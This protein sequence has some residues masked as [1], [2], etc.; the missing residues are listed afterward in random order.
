M[1]DRF[2]AAQGRKV[3]SRTTAEELGTV[4]HLVVD[5]EQRRIVSVVVGRRRKASLVDWQDLSGFGPDAIMVA[6][7]AALRDPVGRHERAAVSGALELRGRRALSDLGNVLGQVDDVIFEPDTGVLETIL[8]GEDEHPAAS[9]LGAGSFAVI[10]N[11][12]VDSNM[13]G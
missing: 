4:R 6:D 13:D 10:L 8:V 11:L 9:L 7:E 1:S 3:V 5:G 12:R 2:T